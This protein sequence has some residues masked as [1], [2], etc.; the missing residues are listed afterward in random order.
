[1]RDA[2]PAGGDVEIVWKGVPAGLMQADAAPIKL[3]ADAFESVLGVRPLLVRSGGTLP[4]V[5]A[6]AEKGIQTVITGF[7]TPESSVHSPNE[8]MLYRY[9]EQGIDV[10]AAVYTELGALTD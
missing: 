2:A 6:L 8:K 10:A 5:P 4:I 7:G 1:M 3:C 9:F